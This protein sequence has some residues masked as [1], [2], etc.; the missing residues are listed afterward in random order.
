[1]ATR[2]TGEKLFSLVCSANLDVGKVQSAQKFFTTE[3]PVFSQAINFL[4]TG[5]NHTSCTVLVI[6]LFF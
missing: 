5:E 6:S 1:L 3:M 2:L 4:E